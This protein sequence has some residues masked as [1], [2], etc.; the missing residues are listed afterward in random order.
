MANSMVVHIC[1]L[2]VVFFKHIHCCFLKSATNVLVEMH[3]C[4]SGVKRF[5]QEQLLS[6]N[7]P[8][9]VFHNK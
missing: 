3:Y 8:A 2:L 7:S 1:C 9:G 6:L 4:L 5:I